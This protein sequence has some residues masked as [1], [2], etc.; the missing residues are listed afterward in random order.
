M[1]KLLSATVASPKAQKTTRLINT[2]LCACVLSFNAFV[3]CQEF[4]L[5]L[6]ALIFDSILLECHFQEKVERTSTVFSE[7]KTED[8]VHQPELGIYIMYEFLYF[9]GFKFVGMDSKICKQNCSI[10]F[11]FFT[12]GFIF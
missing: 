12:I 9:V 3:Y 11:V 4:A 7:P 1:P 2:D 10:N 8:T 6:L 5:E